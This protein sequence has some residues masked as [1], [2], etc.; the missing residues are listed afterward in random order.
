MLL[1]LDERGNIRYANRMT[2]ERLGYSHAELLSMTL[3]QID[4]PTTPERLQAVFAECR[5]AQKPP[6][7]R[8]YRCKDG[9]E[10]PVEI[11]ATVLE[12][13]GEW[14]MHVVP[15]DIRERRQAEQAIRWAASHDGLTELANRAQATRFLEEGLARARSAGKSGALVFID[16][17]RFKPVNDIYGHD[18]GDRVLQEVARRCAAACAM[19]TCWRVSAATSS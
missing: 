7:E 17:D 13:K 5:S 12:H 4:L 3:F 19:T 15:R 1:L 9:A 2:S 6:F 11:T 10:I 14:L 16:L 18:A 8:V